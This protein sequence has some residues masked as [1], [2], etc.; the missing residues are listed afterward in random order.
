MVCTNCGRKFKAGNAPDETPN[1]VTFVLQNNKKIT[2]CR[3]CIVRLGMMSKE[4]QDKLIDELE[5]KAE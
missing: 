5:K 4:N 1:G 3:Y 2:M